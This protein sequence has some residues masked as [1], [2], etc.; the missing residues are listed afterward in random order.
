MKRVFAT[1]LSAALLLCGCGTYTGQGAHTGAGFG[2]V[3]G[4]AIGGITGGPRGH[5]V[6]TIVGMAGG[7]V[8]GAAV[9]NAA[10]KKKQQRYEDYKQ[11]RQGNYGA[12]DNGV[13]YGGA[14]GDDSGFDPNHGG[15]DRIVFDEPTSPGST[16]Q[17]ETITPHSISASQLDKLMPGYSINYNSQI[18]I[19]NAA[20][21]DSDGD[22]VL[23]AG[24]QSKVSFEI[25][26]RSN[27]PI[28]NV[29]PTV[30]ETTGNKRIHISP[31][32]CIEQI[33][34]RR[35]VR[36]TATVM[37]D[38][39]LKKGEINIRIAVAQ[40]GNEITSQIKEFKIITKKK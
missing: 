18:E 13:Q 17:P 3:L 23:K 15:D 35:G 8:V 2:M 37:G 6:G 28:R 34:P 14:Q 5:D 25:M 20:F 24:E 1:A 40:D 12:Y 36:Y 31:S 33:M 30:I 16:V 22:G 7:A 27:R 39:R 32:I 26:N 4:S 10:E 11:Q 38:R 19:C 29:M 21:I 9:G